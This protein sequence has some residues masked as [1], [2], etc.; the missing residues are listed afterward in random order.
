M[1]TQ[2]DIT[3]SDSEKSENW[4]DQV[5][6]MMKDLQTTIIVDVQELMNENIKELMKEM[7]VSVRNNIVDTMKKII[8]VQRKFMPPRKRSRVHTMLDRL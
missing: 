6:D 1:E 5:F 4:K 3:L 7:A 8:T 2:D